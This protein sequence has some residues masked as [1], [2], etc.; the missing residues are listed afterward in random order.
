MLYARH[1]SLASFLLLAAAAAAQEPSPSGGTAEKP[2][3]LRVYANR[4]QVA[5]LVLDADGENLRGVTADKFRLSMDSGP[6]FH[7]SRVRVEEDD[8]INLSI[9]LDG[10]VDRD[11]LNAAVAQLPRLAATDLHPSDRISIYAVD[12]NLVG[13][14]NQAPASAELMT[15]ALASALNYPSLRRPNGH[16]CGS[17]VKLW[18]A[19][20]VA[21]ARMQNAPGRRVLLLISQGEDGG[22]TSTPGTLSNA[23]ISSGIA[24]F[25]IRNVPTFYASPQLRASLASGLRG[26]P[27]SA[28]TNR[29]TSVNGGLTFT[30]DANSMRLTLQHF[31]RLLRTRYILEFPTPDDGTPGYHGLDIQ[32]AKANEVLSTGVGW[33]QMEPSLKSAPDV[34]QSSPSTTVIGNKR[35]Q[36]PK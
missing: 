35:P 6:A 9:L 7:P 19:A 10:T 29:I 27:G 34:V 15:K 20:A 11:L 30:I 36:Q 33:T 17:T 25:A 8:P 13:S 3:T 22:S 32:V 14:A 12:C 4:M 26:D 28:D 23:A 31:A 2:Y 24:V 16:H 5:A 21:V 1:R 18:D